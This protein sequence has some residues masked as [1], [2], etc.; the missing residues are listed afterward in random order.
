M[1]GPHD[2][3]LSQAEQLDN[4]HHSG[5]QS[6]ASSL[7]PQIG[8]D[9]SINCLLRCSRSD[10]GLV[11]AVDGGGGA[12][13]LGCGGRRR[14]GSSGVGLWWS[15]VVVGRLPVVEISDGDSRALSLFSENFER[16]WR[17]KG[18]G[19]CVREFFYLQNDIVLS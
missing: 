14:W 6:D 11:A 2:L 10:Y 9:N 3:S 15:P 7:I 1:Q 16:Q 8:R 5:D 4:E 17:P 12:L 19:F 13:G 18:K